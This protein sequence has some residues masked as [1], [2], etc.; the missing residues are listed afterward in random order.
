MIEHYKVVAAG[1]GG[2]ITD[3]N[4][5]CTAQ[6]EANN[7]VLQWN[8]NGGSIPA[9][10]TTGAGGSSCTYDDTITLPDPELVTKPGYTFSGWSVSNSAN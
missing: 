7:I 9:A 10:G 5:T 8:A 1:Q 3:A 4:V 6:W 2:V